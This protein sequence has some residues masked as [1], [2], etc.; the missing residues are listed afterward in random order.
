V[1]ST[2]EIWAVTIDDGADISARF[3]AGRKRP[4]IRVI[5]AAE[6]K[7]AIEALPIF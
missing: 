5:A 2:A 4:T 6:I 7:S 1:W 3:A